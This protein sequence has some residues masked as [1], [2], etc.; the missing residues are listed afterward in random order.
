MLRE[1][2]NQAI[3]DISKHFQKG[4]KKVLL[5]LST[6]AGKTVIFCEMIKRTVA[7]GKTATVIVRGRSLVEQASDRLTRE[8][9]DHGIFMAGYREIPGFTQVIS[10]D[11]A[12]SRKLE[13]KSNLLIV[14]EAHLAVT[15][16]FKKVVENYKGFLVAVTATPYTRQSLRHLADAVVSPI[17]MQDLIYQG[18]LVPARYFAPMVP[19][20]KGVRTVA[21]EFEKS[22]LDSKMRELTGKV[23]DNWIKFGQN[24]PT[25][26]FAVSI[27]HSKKIVDDFLA[28]GIPAEHIEADTPST[29]RQAAIWRLHKG[30]TKVICNVG[31]LCTGV[32]IPFLGCVLMARPTKSYNL[33]IQQAGRGTRIHDT[34]HDFILLDC[35]GN[36]LRHGFITE[37]KEVFLD[38]IPKGESVPLVKI[39]PEC[40]SIYQGTRC[41]SCGY[42]EVRSEP[43]EIEEVVGEL[44]ELKNMPLQYEIARFV[45]SQKEIALRLKYKAGWVYWRVKE[46]YGEE[47]AAT[48]YP[49]ISKRAQYLSLRSA[50]RPWKTRK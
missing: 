4:I 49:G 16:E 7:R 32:D 37:E 12:I 34:K 42:L 30:Q 14:D 2:Q 33:Y 48:L 35:A 18:Y 43:G 10:A 45:R 5:H 40:Y 13:I 38:G 36:V 23:V 21:G 3:A 22:L 25:V 50:P 19:D 28:R 15:G 17:K 39:C 11:T 6:G 9:V 24:R 29:E 47:I 46:K 31:I 27:E 1:Y 26:C 44:G 20:L 41:L 8:K